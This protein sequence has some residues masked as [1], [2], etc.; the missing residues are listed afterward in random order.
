MIKFSFTFFSIGNDIARPSGKF[1]IPIPIARV[2]AF[3]TDSGLLL[4]AKAPKATPIAAPS[5]ML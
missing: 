5:G 3:I 1:W 4:R 2:K